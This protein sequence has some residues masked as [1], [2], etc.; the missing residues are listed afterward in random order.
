M[1]SLKF[2]QCTKMEDLLKCLIKKRIY[3]FINMILFLY[4]DWGSNFR[5][6]HFK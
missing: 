3:T 6:S 1:Y 5:E 4:Q 2:H